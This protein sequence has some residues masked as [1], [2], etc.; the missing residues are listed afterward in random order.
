MRSKR[1]VQIDDLAATKSYIER[2]PTS[3]EAVELGG[4]RTMLAVPMLKNEKLIGI[5]TIVRQQVRPFVDKQIGLVTNFAAQ[6]V[7]AI[8]NARLLNELRQR[9]KDLGEALDQ[10]TATA[11]VL[12]VIS[13][14]QF[15]LQ[16]VLDNLIETA[17]SLCG[18]K[19]GVIF[20][21][22][23]DLYHA[24]AF[25]NATPE[26]IEFVKS[27]PIAPGR[28]TVTARVA[29]ERRVIH[30]ADLQEDAEYTY[31][32]RDTEPIRTELGVPMF[33]GEDLVGVFILYKL[34]IEPFT[35]KQIELVTTFTDQA[36]IAIENVRLLNELRQSTTDLRDALE[37]QT[38]T[39]EVL[40]VI[41]RSPSDLEPV[42]ASMLDNAVRIC[43]A[44]FGSIYRWTGGALH[45]VATRNAPAGYAEA[46]RRMAISVP[47][48]DPMDRALT[49][50]SIV[51]IADLAAEPSYVAGR[52]PQVAL[53]VEQGGYAPACSFL[54][55]WRTNQSAYLLCFDRR[56]APSLTKR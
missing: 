46:R 49:T 44:K 19:R 6:A 26:L 17:T 52:N 55:C 13:R 7:I 10:Q 31:A 51:H 32:L 30:V 47:Q 33:R 8:E 22:D 2:H 5:I 27:H 14:S 9:T 18:A 20:R 41:S 39:S 16:L 3:V 53:P 24:A 28:H 25:Y 36:V 54:C 48:D 56:S 34:K 43:D 1:T 42:F 15:D 23:G 35:D 12:K 11:D 4:I 37:R 50:K 29:L 45:L 38:A 40:Q 21:A